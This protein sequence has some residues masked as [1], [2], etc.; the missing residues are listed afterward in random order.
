M[1][2]QSRVTGDGMEKNGFNLT[3]ETTAL[4]YA[5]E[6]AFKHV[7]FADIWS[8]VNKKAL[9]TWL[10]KPIAYTIKNT[11][12]R[13]FKAVLPWLS[14]ERDEQ[15][16]IDCFCAELMFSWFYVID[17]IADK[18]TLRY[19]TTTSYGVYGIETCLHTLDSGVN[20]G[21][22]GEMF[23]DGDSNR[24]ELW[25]SLSSKLV[26]LQNERLLITADA[27]DQ[28]V[29]NSVKRT[30]FLA[31]WW[32]HTATKRH[33]D[34]LREMIGSIYSYCAL[35]GQLRNDL[36]NLT[37]REQDDGGIRFSDFSFGKATAV[38]MTVLDASNR[39]EYEWIIDCVWNQR[40]SLTSKE[41]EVLY[42]ICCSSGAIERVKSQILDLY[43]LIETTILSSNIRE[44]LKIIWLGWAKRQFLIGVSMGYKEYTNFTPLFLD[45]VRESFL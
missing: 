22:F 12:F 3:H 26:E 39:S 6:T 14:V 19:G 45:S 15:L 37:E 17:D 44:Q 40:R 2:L 23:L 34:D 35:A 36:R 25:Q 28:Y 5:V 16:L 8:R 11:P 27:H 32:M 43:I 33:D 18:K 42:K 38:T 21:Q 29:S 7:F 24:I 20:I 9:N 31:D 41:Q 10:G 30:W 13:K 4:Y 1:S